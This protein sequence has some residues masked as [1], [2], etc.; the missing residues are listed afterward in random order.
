MFNSG[1]TLHAPTHAQKPTPC[2]ALRAWSLLCLQGEKVLLSRWPKWAA[3]AP[4]T[5]SAAASLSGLEAVQAA[6]QGSGALGKAA[7]QFLEGAADLAYAK[8]IAGE[9]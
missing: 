7:Q 2:S 8:G 5:S 4:A 9:S 6:V 1:V 3:T